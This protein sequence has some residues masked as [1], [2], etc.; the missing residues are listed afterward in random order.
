MHVLPR[1]E[2]WAVNTK[3]IYRLYKGL[4]LQLRSKAPRRRVNA[5]ELV[6]ELSSRPLRRHQH[7]RSHRSLP[8]VSAVAGG[9]SKWLLDVEHHRC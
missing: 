5:L 2:G 6:R 7:S 8:E 3:R 9:G 1:Q 4:G